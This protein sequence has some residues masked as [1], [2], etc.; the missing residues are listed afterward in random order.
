MLIVD[1]S[2]MVLMHLDNSQHA[3]SHVYNQLNV[4]SKSVEKFSQIKMIAIQ[5][6]LDQHIFIILFNAYSVS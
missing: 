4:H 3:H 1:V 6:F 2:F 5:N